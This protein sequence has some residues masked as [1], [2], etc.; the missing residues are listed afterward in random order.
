[1]KK[2]FR[3][4]LVSILIIMSV[5]MSA[6]SKKDGSGYLF[7]YTIYNNPK[8]L[9]PQMAT[10]NESMNIIRNMFEGLVT[11]E[12]NGIIKNGVAKSY[13]VSSDG[14][15]YTFK[16]KDNLYWKSVNE[17]KEKLTADDFVFTFER[18]A[19]KATY[20]PYSEEFFCIAGFEDVY[21]GIKSVDKLGVKAVSE[22]ELQ[23]KLAHPYAEFLNLLSQTCAFPCKRD[24]FNASKGM[25]GLEVEHTASNGAFFL[26]SWEY[27]PYGKNNFLILRKNVFYDK[28]NKVY[29]SSLNYFVNKEEGSGVSNFLGESTDCLLDN[30]KSEKLYTRKTKNSSYIS[31]TGGLIFNPANEIFKDAEIRKALALAI[32][33]KKFTSLP[34]YLSVANGVVP[35]AVKIVNKSYRELVADP[36][37]MEGDQSQANYMWISALTD[38]QKDELALATILVSDKSPAADYYKEVSTSWKKTLDLYC[39]VEVVSQSE[40]EKRIKDGKYYIASVDINGQMNSPSAFLDVFLTGNKDNIW[41]LSIGEYDGYI[42]KAK[43]SLTISEAVDNYG[44]AE[45]CL[46]DNNMFIPVFYNAE[47]LVYRKDMADFKFDPFCNQINFVKAKKY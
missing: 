26:R 37:K 10:D 25:Y 40:Y 22:N 28:V 8:N 30:G 1:M 29:P 11:L 3:L 9:D 7:R 38:K 21:E 43:S 44:K 34:D 4:S 12:N 2:I 47:Y 39:P 45:K 16:L 31:E 5:L 17:Y 35:P 15:T 42:A 19:S 13:T 27:D 23:I 46:I 20:S 6:C 36:C 41:G 32:N 14:L 24:F 33:R 18:L